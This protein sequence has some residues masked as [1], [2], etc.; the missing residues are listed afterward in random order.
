[1]SIRPS[2][3]IGKRLAFYRTLAGMSAQQLS[4]AT[5]GFVSRSAIANLESDK[6]RKKDLTVDELLALSW[7]MQIPPVALALP[8][9]EPNRWVRLSEEVR[10]RTALAVKWFEEG[11][12]GSLDDERG[13]FIS[14][15][16][17]AATA[18]THVATERLRWMKEW[19]AEKGTV[20]RAAAM[21]HR[22][23][24]DSNWEAIAAES[25]ERLNEIASRLESL[26]VDLSDFKIDD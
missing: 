12:A 24:T 4:D 16:A 1:M 10:V 13:L 18:A 7:A 6:P 23:N 25:R 20:A 14:E 19:W 2:E 17:T 5:G 21:M 9:E 11:R 26:G 15:R 8:L 3:G 22:G